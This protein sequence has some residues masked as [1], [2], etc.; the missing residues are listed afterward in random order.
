MTPVYKLSNAGGFTS[1]QKYTSML[2]GN[3]VFSPSAFESIA[4]YSVGSGGVADITF[5]SIPATYSHL[6]IRFI[7]AGSSADMDVQ[8]RFNSDSG[9]NY[10]RHRMYGGGSSAATDAG[11]NSTKIDTFGR[12]GSGA[13]IYGGNVVD[14]LDYANT[15]KYK[16]TR[17]LFGRDSN[18]DG[19]I[20]FSS[21][22]WMNTNAI[23]SILL[24]PQTGNFSQYSHFALYGIKGAA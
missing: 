13:S 8:A 24:F 11:T 2:A 16:T 6:Q 1:K 22:L 4:T 20:M 14:I 18:G 19:F 3:T 5:S 10:A 15:N 23:T 21:G 9:A 17:S 12:T 7:A